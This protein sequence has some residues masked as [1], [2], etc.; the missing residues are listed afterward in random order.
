VSV[1][2][3]RTK[4]IGAVVAIVTAEVCQGNKQVIVHFKYFINDGVFY[5]NSDIRIPKTPFVFTVN[6]LK[7]YHIKFNT[8]YS[9]SCVITSIQI[10]PHC[11]WL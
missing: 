9:V 4:E 5:K 10:L 11:A 2:I 3:K 8:T 1:S 6:A 7:A